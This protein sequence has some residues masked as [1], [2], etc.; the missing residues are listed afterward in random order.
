MHFSFS[1]LL[2]QQYQNHYFRHPK[3]KPMKSC[4]LLSFFFFAIFLQAQPHSDNHRIVVKIPA[5]VVAKENLLSAESFLASRLFT[6][7]H[8]QFPPLHIHQF[9]CGRTEDR[10]F[11]LQFDQAHSSKEI[12]EVYGAIAEVEYAELDGVGT[13]AGQ[14]LLTPNDTHFS[15]QW[16]LKNDGGFSLSPALA[17]ADVQMEDAWSFTQGDSSIIVAIMDSGAKMDHPEFQGRIWQNLAEIPGNG[18]DDDLNGYID[19]HEGWDFANNDNNPTDDQGHGS[20]VMGILGANGNNAIGYAGIDWNCKLMV[21]KGL[22][23]SNSGFYTWW[24]EAIYY[25]VDHGAKVINLSVGG[26]SPSTALADAIAYAINNNVV[27]V[28]CMMNTNNNTPYIPAIYPGVIAVGSTNPND[29]RSA[30]FF[31]SPS[32]GSNFGPHITVCAPGNYIYGLSHTSNTNYNGYWGGTSQATPLVA[33]IA[34]LLLAQDPSRTIQDIT[35]ILILTAE[36]QVGNPAED[37]PGW[38]QYYGYGRVNAYEAL[39]YSQSA[40]TP[41]HKVDGSVLYPNPNLGIFAIDHEPGMAEIQVL[42]AYG[43]VVFKSPLSSSVKRTEISLENVSSGMYYALV[44]SNGLLSKS[45]PF[46]IKE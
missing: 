21:L 43:Q 26:S 4:A 23:S 6:D 36:D 38:D 10:I 8:T 13:G 19:D 2:N 7:V 28:A 22:N 44:F 18:I 37:T 45:F 32:S 3:P 14:Q 31:W 41:L 33:G 11:V 39:A 12:L 29:T 24:A 9:R 15:R 40:S 20:N 25:A 30:P 34:S 1:P 46:I 16:G 5:E 17:G 27:V 35:E 42:N